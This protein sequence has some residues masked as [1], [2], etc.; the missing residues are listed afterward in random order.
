[1]NKEDRKVYKECAEDM[2]YC[3]ICGTPHNLHIHHIRHGA[4]GRK[5]YKGNII[6]LCSQCHF[7]VHKNTKHWTPILV[8]HVNKIYN[9]DLPEYIKP[10]KCVYSNMEEEQ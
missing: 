2:P 10:D 4:N 9:L 5:T 6:R 3:Q 1:M 7:M 8:K